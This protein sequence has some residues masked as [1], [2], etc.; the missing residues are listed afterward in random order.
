MRKEKIKMT[1]HC[2]VCVCP[3]RYIPLQRYAKLCTK[4]IAVA[5]F[6]EVPTQTIS[7][8]QPL[9]ESV[10]F[11]G[12]AKSENVVGTDMYSLYIGQWL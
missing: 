4:N 3:R 11:N 1:K 5:D 6:V 9:F 10:F 2:Y 7:F 8:N 12:G